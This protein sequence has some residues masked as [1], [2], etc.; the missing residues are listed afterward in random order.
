MSAIKVLK[1]IF[2]N[3]AAIEYRGLHVS[4]EIMADI[5][6]W[7]DEYREGIDEPYFIYV[8]AEVVVDT[9]AFRMIHEDDETRYLRF[10]GRF[11]FDM[12]SE[13]PSDSVILSIGHALYKSQCLDYEQQIEQLDRKLPVMTNQAASAFITCNNETI[14][15]LLSTKVITAADW[16]WGGQILPGCDRQG[17]RAEFVLKNR[18]GIIMTDIRV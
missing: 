3:K 4:E 15:N 2:C 11:M 5:E 18:I 17:R 10:D 9:A 12:S 16:K 7:N 13:I 6:A 1:N 8:D 14:R